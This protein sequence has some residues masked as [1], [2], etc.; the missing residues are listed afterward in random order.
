MVFFFIFHISQI[1]HVL[2]VKCEAKL[3]E[4]FQPLSLNIYVE[5]FF[6]HWIVALTKHSIRYPP[7]CEFTIHNAENVKALRECIKKGAQNKIK[8]NREKHKSK[9]IIEKTKRRVECC[10][11]NQRRVNLQAFYAKL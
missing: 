4:T 9:Y 11:C 6:F 10:V 8:K 3:L 5:C 1:I 2:E 7:D